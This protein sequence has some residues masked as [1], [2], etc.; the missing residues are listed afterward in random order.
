MSMSGQ[1]LQ[2]QSVQA[3]MLIPLYGRAKMSEL[4]P[5]LIYDS[6]AI[7]IVSK[8]D[9]DF[10][11]IERAFGEYG[12]ASY[13]A[14]ARRMD[15]EV[16]AFLKKYPYSTVVNIGAGLDT[17]FSRVD[18]GKVLWYNLDLPDAI[19]YR[20]NLI[21]PTERS[22]DIPKSVFDYSWLDDI[23]LG[24]DGQLLLIAAGVFF[25]L[26][27]AQL[28]K[29]MQNVIGKFPT[30]E[31]FFDAASGIGYKMSNR[32]VKKSGNSG[33]EMQFYVNGSKPLYKWSPK[34]KRVEIIPFF[35]DVRGMIK[36]TL[37]TRIQMRLCDM[38]GMG[39]Y[40]RVTW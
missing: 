10:S 26:K 2:T 40:V 12:G 18:N 17:T 1:P 5:D 16:S 32:L 21:Q 38:L 35:G 6:E 31:L 9:M 22:M 19:T 11:R 7:R 37:G 4:Y 13:L 23:I 27:G 24:T 36:W 39:K 28:R 14:R 30:G 15:A 33:A 29:M 25:Y 8:I 3:T 34:I 20:Q